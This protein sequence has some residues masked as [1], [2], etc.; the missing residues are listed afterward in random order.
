MRFCFLAG[1]LFAATLLFGCSPR[2][3]RP[4]TPTV[5]SFVGKVVADGKPVQ[6]GDND[7][8]ELEIFSSKGTQSRIALKPDGSFK[9]GWMEID[10]YT[11]TLMRTKAGADGKPA[12]GLSRHGIPGFE[13]KAGQ[14]EYT[15]ELGKNY[16]P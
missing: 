4:N 12:G 11:G 1:A 15:I 10:N 2:S 6:F 14:T 3:D 5:D 16:K 13:I 9:I 7:L 8:V